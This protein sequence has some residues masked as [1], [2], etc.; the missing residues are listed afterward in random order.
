MLYYTYNMLIVQRVSVR[1]CSRQLILNAKPQ[2][3][4]AIRMVI[5]STE[6]SSYTL[7]LS[8]YLYQLLTESVR[9]LMLKKNG[10][11]INRVIE[12]Y[13]SFFPIVT[14]QVRR[15]NDK[16]NNNNIV[17]FKYRLRYSPISL[18]TNKLLKRRKKIRARSI[19]IGG[20]CDRYIHCKQSFH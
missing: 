10:E 14:L 13:S 18:L 8:R 1:V 15:Y 17:F 7:R 16:S 19:V 11:E 2:L 4:T 3:W 20:Y 12:H 9:W 5:L 6:R